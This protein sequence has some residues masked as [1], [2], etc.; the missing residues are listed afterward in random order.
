MMPPKAMLMSVVC[1]AAMGHVNNHGFMMPSEALLVS[2]FCVDAEGHVVLY[3]LV[4]AG[5]HVRHP[6]LYGCS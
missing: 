6:Q 3:G 1:P 4:S 5:S 2:M